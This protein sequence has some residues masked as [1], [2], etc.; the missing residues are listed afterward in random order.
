MLLNALTFN[1]RDKI[2]RILSLLRPEVRSLIEMDYS[3]NYT[4]VFEDA[5]VACIEDQEDLTI[6]LYTTMHQKIERTHCLFRLE[7][8]ANFYDEL[9]SCLRLSAT[10]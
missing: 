4:K 3:C 5:V 7:R 6:F 1:P 8:T 2:Y 10:R 9:N